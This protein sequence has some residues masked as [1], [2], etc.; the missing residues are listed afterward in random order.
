MKLIDSHLVKL[1]TPLG[2][3]PIFYIN[4]LKLASND[5]LPNQVQDNYQPQPLEVDGEKE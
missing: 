1:D 2:L 3:H 5:L 4:R